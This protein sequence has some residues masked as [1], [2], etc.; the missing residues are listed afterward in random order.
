MKRST[1]P[2]WSTPATFSIARYIDWMNAKYGKLSVRLFS[3]LHI[4]HMLHGM[5]CA[6]AVTPGKVNDPPHLRL[7]TEMLPEGDG[8][9]PADAAYDGVKNCNAIRDSGRRSIIDSKSNAVIKGFNAGAEMSRFG[10]KHPGT[11]HRILRLRNNVKERLLVH[12]GAV[13]RCRAPPQ[14]D[15]PVG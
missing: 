12:E 7:M 2:C 4:M 5:V 15:D 14:G 11:S 9:V 1:A 10:K 6:A 8:N 3:K 13:R